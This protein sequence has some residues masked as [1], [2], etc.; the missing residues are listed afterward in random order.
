MTEIESL[1]IEL[2][3]LAHLEAE[4]AV[5]TA[6]LTTLRTQA[7]KD[8]HEL[9]RVQKELAHALACHAELKKEARGVTERLDKQ[10]DFV[11]VRLGQ[12]ATVR[13]SY[14]VTCCET[15]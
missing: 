9:E 4:V 5:L 11:K 12:Q 14:L 10:T 1:K 2:E 3:K 7:A 15:Y 6:N 13:L 8:A